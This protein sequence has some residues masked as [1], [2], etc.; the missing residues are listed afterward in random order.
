M[1]SFLL[2]H[3]CLL[4]FDFCF[5]ISQV[6]GAKRRNL[7]HLGRVLT[8]TSRYATRALAERWCAAGPE[9]LWSRELGDGYSAIAEDAGM[10]FTMYRR[11]KSHSIVIA[12]DAATGKTRWE[13]P[14]EDSPA[15]KDLHYGPGPHVMPQVVAGRVFA[16]AISGKMFCLDEKSGKVIW[17]HDLGADFKAQAIGSRLRK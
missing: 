7:A 1:R 11:D 5:L 10:L 17:N 9:K 4:I 13:Y 6:F 14:F 12:L 8:T 3:F 16:A 15:G 2:P